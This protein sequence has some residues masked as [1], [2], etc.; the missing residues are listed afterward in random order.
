MKG[1][2][3]AEWKEGDRV[4]IK[5]LTDVDTREPD[6]DVFHFIGRMA[7]IVQPYVNDYY[8]C[9]IKLDEGIPELAATFGIPPELAFL[10][11]DLEKAVIEVTR[12]NQF[13]GKEATMQIAITQEELDAGLARSWSHNR[14]GGGTEHMQDIFPQLSAGEREFLMTGITPQEWDAMF[15]EEH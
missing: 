6:S 13:T 5:S 3:V 15:P 2:I 7:T 1:K 14:A 4:R 11:C 9:I 12:K 10:H 8:D